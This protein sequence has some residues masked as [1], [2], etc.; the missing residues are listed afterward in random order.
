MTNTQITLDQVVPIS[1]A[2][3]RLS[4]LVDQIQDEDFVVVSKKYQPQ[5]AL[6]SLAFFKQLLQIYQRWQREQDFQKLEVLRD[7]LP[8]RKPAQVQQDIAA[9][10]K[11]VRKS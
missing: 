3:S 2:R 1:T 9:A 5:A 8:S 6:V 11:T 7:K 4:Q 10:L